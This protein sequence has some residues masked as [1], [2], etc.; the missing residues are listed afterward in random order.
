MSGPADGTTTT[1][2]TTATTVTTAA[3]RGW[4]LPAPGGTAGKEDRGRALVV[5]GSTRTPGAVLLAAEAAVRC[6]AG[7]LQVATTASTAVPLAVA[8]P[9][10]M[11]LPLPEAPG[12]AVDAGGDL[13]ELAEL[14]SGAD[15]VLVGPGLVDVDRSRALVVAL[16]PAVTG[17]LVLDALGLAV[18][19]A[20]PAALGE[21]AARTVLT[22]NP[23]ELALTL[24]A[25]PAEVSADL[26]GAARELAR[27]TGATVAAG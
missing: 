5:G 12:G 9:E 11:V 21:R 18:L 16:L 26:A 17:A 7:K 15:A 25:E 27:R 20:D 19:T 2:T 22:P 6:G 24:G 8:L 14:V 4:P 1:A 23:T 10:A 13:A 3:L